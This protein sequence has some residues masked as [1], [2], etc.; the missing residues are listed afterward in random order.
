MYFKYNKKYK[1]ENVE[2]KIYF[3][4][5]IPYLF[6]EKC[7]KTKNDKYFIKPFS[8]EFKKRFTAKVK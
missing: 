1:E 7:I 2:L 8:K 5:I 4:H 3:V 6:L